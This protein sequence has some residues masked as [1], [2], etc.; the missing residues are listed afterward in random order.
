MKIPG[1]FYQRKVLMKRVTLLIVTMTSMLLL[2]AC[3][4]QSFQKV[5]ASR[6][7][8]AATVSRQSQSSQKAKT[9]KNAQQYVAKL[10]QSTNAKITGVRYADNTVTWTVS[11]GWANTPR[12]SLT[13][14]VTKLIATTQMQAS[15][16]DQKTPNIVIEQANGKRVCH[17]DVG[18]DIVWDNYY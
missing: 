10:R 13:H 12:R 6:T 17:Q 9:A 5:S 3:G 2:A 15:L 7:A 4:Q 8:A 14:A 16:H 11:K 18:Y 1:I